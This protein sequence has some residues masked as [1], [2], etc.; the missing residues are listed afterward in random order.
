MTVNLV[1]EALHVSSELRYAIG[2]GHAGLECLSGD[3]STFPSAYPYYLVLAKDDEAR[4]EIVK[5]TARSGQ[6]FTV[7]R[8]SAGTTACAHPQGEKIEL[9][10]IGTQTGT[11]QTYGTTP[12]Q[13]AAGQVDGGGIS[14]ATGYGAGSSNRFNAFEVNADTGG[15]DLTGDT[16]EAA[17]KA[18]IVIG[19][20]QSNAS[21]IGML[22]AMNF[23]DECDLT[24]GNYFAVRGHFDVWDDIDTSGA[25]YAG[26]I[27]AYVENE[28]TTTI[29]SGTWLS[30]LDIYQVGSPTI[31]SGGYNPAI[32]IRA[33][34]QASAWQ[35]GIFMSPTSV[36]NI[37]YAGEAG[38]PITCDTAS[39]K[40]MQVYC[41]CGATSGT[42]VGFYIREYLTGAGGSNAVM[43]VYSDVVGVAAATA[44]G[45]QC[46]LGFGE[47]TTTGSV[48]GL[49]VAGRFQIGLANTAYPGTGTIA[50]IQAEIYSFGTDSD[51]AGN[52]IAMFRVVNDG[53]G[54]GPAD[55]DDDAVLFNFAGW[56]VEA[57]HMIQ[58]D[59]GNVDT[60]LKCKLPD[61]S[62]GYLMMTKT[63][64]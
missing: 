9:M 16:Y 30:G 33:S 27:S 57:G 2:A 51:P 23:G 60:L 24:G 18:N 58:T 32:H 35:W 48:T 54:N 15:T 21:L 44:Q 55:V 14:L 8:G 47:S 62:L 49:G 25:T 45:M 41:D 46:S 17:I 42:S 39:T 31:T 10:A 22:A 52:N 12:T 63:I 4:T 37:L 1:T 36:E 11:T 56:T 61:G 28:S 40:F 20:A 43:R 50:C 53:V 34:S 13:T 38:S 64:T 3:A 6:Y 7:T 5:V 29:G 59:T 19:T 26:A